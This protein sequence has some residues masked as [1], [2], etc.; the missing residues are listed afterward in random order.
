[1]KQMNIKILLLALLQ[2]P[3][4]VSCMG[5]GNVF[6]V[7]RKRLEFMKYVQEYRYQQAQESDDDYKL[8]IDVKQ[9]TSTP[10]NRRRINR[11]QSRRRGPPMSRKA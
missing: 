9:S 5:Q 4:I 3:I 6:S 2:L 10:I 7:I 1:M 8:V 11:R